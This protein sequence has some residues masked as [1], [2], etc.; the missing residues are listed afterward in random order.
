MYLRPSLVLGLLITSQF[1]FSQQVNHN[2]KG[3]VTDKQSKEQ[4][5]GAIISIPELKRNTVAKLD[6]TFSLD[7]I[8]AGTYHIRCSYIG[9]VAVD[10]VV[11]VNGNLTLNL[12]LNNNTAALN[13]VVVT[14][15]H[16]VESEAAAKKSEQNASSVMN[17][18]SAKAIQLSPDITVG[19]V[20]QRVSGVSIE[21][22]S[23]GDGRY[24]IIRGM[25]QRYNNTLING[26]K[27]PSPDNKSRFVPLD[28]FPS[29]LIER[30]EVNKTLTPDMEADA[31]GGTVNM[32]MKNAP[33][34]LYINAS[35]ATG[36]SQTVLQNGFD[37][38]PVSAIHKSSP[39]QQ[40]GPGYSATPADFTRD[41]LNYTHK[42]APANAMGTLSIGNRFFNNRFGIMLGG[43]YQNIYKAY[44]SIFNPGEFQEEGQLYVK[45]A[46]LRDYS[47]HLTRTGLNA[48]FDFDINPK[49]KIS[50]YSVY[51]DLKD[52]QARLTTDSLMPYPRTVAGTGQVWQFGRSKYQHQNI[53]SNTLQGN[54]TIVDNRLKLDW[55]AVYSKAMSEIPDWAEYEY[56]GGF[57]TDPSTPNNP[58]YKH[59]DV[60]QNFNRT[61][62]KNS[63]RDLA[64]YLN[65]HYTNTAWNTPYTISVG[66]LYR[67]KHR[68]N[69]YDNYELRPV[70]NADGSKQL[71]TDIYHFN[72]TVFNPKGSP[73]E[74]NNY[75]A[76][77]RITAGYLLLKFKINKLETVAGVRAENTDQ[78]FDTD[79]PV[80]QNAKSGTISYMDV[81][82]SVNFKYELN[83]KTNLRLS[84]YAAISRPAF[85]EIVPYSYHGDQF[86]EK[87]NPNLLHST[88]NNV[89]LRYELFPKTNEQILIGA[90]YK[91]IQ[92]PIEYGFEF[93]GAQNQTA[94]MPGNYGDVTNYGFELVY[95]KYL[96]NFGIRANYTYTHSQITT[97]K[98]TSV[99][100][101]GVLQKL[102]LNESRPLQGQSDHVA[103]AAFLYKNGKLGLD[104]QLAWQYTGKRIVL[105]SPYYGF[106]YWQK[107]MNLF[108]FSAEKRF[109]KHFAVFAK[110]QNLLDAKYEV[111]INKPVVN[112]VPVPFQNPGSGKTLAQRDQYGQ[113]YILGLRFLLNK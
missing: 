73:G 87:G 63:D 12:P 28:I 26:I 97:T 32:V 49:H 109:A 79:V 17:I 8:P 37:Y 25:D 98:M 62:W 55:S 7:R 107:G 102:F 72:W 56:D 16:N 21:R 50:L 2:I 51:A 40:N 45:H 33:E 5:I 57:Y 48:K 53:F 6:G 92:N 64:G 108:D 61:W 94:Y 99:K 24:A 19:N 69:K 10:T 60:L 89:D 58:P 18:I 3:A 80:T 30:I 29:E 71:W 4:L 65:L 96:G 23:N 90:F 31:V 88:S 52:A 106:D 20:L 36:F 67:D 86:D 77:E 11:T 13:E 46:Y 84:Y 81:L 35:A 59:P 82:P 15:K 76:N 111:Y 1:A 95:E 78:D 112:D 22:S 68:D 110:V 91:S 47:S 75:R 41:N 103:N 9:Y 14:G 74:A 54:H 104:V 113:N 66:G 43:S 85:F 70:P 44:N 93:T 83:K 101:D 42:S 38:F 105:V 34:R 39:Y 100:K 27:I